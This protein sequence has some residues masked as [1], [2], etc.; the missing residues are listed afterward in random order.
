MS[1]P[2]KILIIGGGFTGLTAAYQLSRESDFSITLVESSGHLGGLA[3][4]FPL[5]GTS[6]EKAYHHLFLTDTDIL[7]LVEELDL[8]GKLMWCES[9]VGIYRDGRV[10]PFLSPLDLLRF[11]PCSLPGRLRFGL[12][13]LYLQKKKNWRGFATQTA[14]E[15]LARA[16]GSDVMRTIWTPL[17]KGQFDRYWNSVSMAWLWARIHTRANSRPPGGGREKLGYFRGGFA[18]II[19][20][21]ESE[22]SRRKVRILTGKAVQ[23][24]TFGTGRQALLADGQ[25]VDFDL[26]LFTGSSTAFARLLPAGVVPDDY[27]RKLESIAYLG[28]ICL[29]FV[30]DQSIADQYWLNIHEDGAPFLLFIQHT[31]LVGTEMYQG[32]HVYY[33]GS[34]Q[35]HDS[36]LFGM[37]DDALTGKWFDYLQRIYPQFD[38]ARICERH[39]FKFKAAQHVVDTRYEEKIP[40]Y[41]TPVPG[42]F[43]AN[44]SQ[45]FPEDRG[46][47]FAVREGIKVAGMISRELSGKA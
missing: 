2:Q 29:V 23:Q 22:L 6:L 35:P 40:D 5:L 14:E 31:R 30:T 16:C 21:L 43:L 36:A 11:K 44:F 32:R 9:S 10:Y 45:I 26:C 15:W 39:V 42:L 3:A 27:R 19:G 18:E 25:A 38:P 47:N 12:M 24:L 46:T 28:A 8:A 37:S 20:K 1:A 33:I 34:Y 4:G 17:L 7:Q 41:R 13:A